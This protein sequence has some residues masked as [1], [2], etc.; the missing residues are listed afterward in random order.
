MG[1]DKEKDQQRT[2]ARRAFLRTAAKTLATPPAVT[3]LL[4]V[5][6]VRARA[7]EPYDGD[8]MTIDSKLDQF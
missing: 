1:K 6:S 8:G 4:S 7:G 3:M 5:G 2:D